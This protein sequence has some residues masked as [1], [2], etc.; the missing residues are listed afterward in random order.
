VNRH[1]KAVLS[2]KRDAI[3]KRWFEAVARTY[4]ADTARFLQAQRDPFANPVGNTTIRGLNGL[5]D[6]LL[7]EMAPDEVIACLDPIIRIRAVQ[8]F[9]PSRAA[10]FVFA[11]KAIIRDQVGKRGAE[12]SIADGLIDLDGRIDDMGL[13]AFDVY[14]RCKEKVYQI[15][16]NEMRNRTYSAF[17]RAGLVREIPEDGPDLSKT[18]E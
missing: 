17:H 12:G 9:T 16:A 4:P 6:Q 5:F 1:L 7:A 10:G 11:L 18:I 8:S 2:E 14:M 3:V 15:K 13:M